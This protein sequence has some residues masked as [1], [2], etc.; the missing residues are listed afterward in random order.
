MMNESISFT[1]LDE[2]GREVKCEALFT[3][4]SVETGK[5]YIVYTDNSVDE[6]VLADMARARELIASGLALRMNRTDSYGQIKIR[7]P[8]SYASYTG[9]R[10]GEYYEQIMADELNVKRINWIEK[11]ESYKVVGVVAG[12]DKSEQWIE[13]NKELTAELES[14][15][16]SREIIRAVQKARKDAGLNVDDRIELSLSTQDDDV[17]NSIKDWG[18]QISAE[19]LATK[20]TSD[21]FNDALFTAKVKVNKLP[22]TIEINRIGNK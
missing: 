7:Q 2:N 20:L 3:F 17:A 9:Q 12:Q 1:V 19:V 8:L 4:E 21:R 11:L 5:S 14:E 16:L 6:V 18:E 22:L 15:G 13:L 10:L